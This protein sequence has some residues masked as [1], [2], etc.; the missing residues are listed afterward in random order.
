MIGMYS[1]YHE[2]KMVMIQICIQGN[3]LV[4][5]DMERMPLFF[6]TYRYV[7]FMTATL[8][9]L[10]ADGWLKKL[11][12]GRLVTSDNDDGILVS[13]NLSDPTK[14]PTIATILSALSIVPI[15]IVMG[16]VNAI[17]GIN[18][19]LLVI[20]YLVIS[21][22]FLNIGWSYEMKYKWS[23]TVAVFAVIWRA[24]AFTVL[25]FKT[26]ANKNQV[27]PNNGKNDNIAMKPVVPQGLQFH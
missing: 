12:K 6:G 9:S 22:T 17:P 23:I 19:Q 13:S 5:E 24:P 4:L 18:K 7:I 15:G 27:G 8:T 10:I 1:R 14:I 25:T 3:D 16:L 26:K 21:T 20:M 11:I 2:D